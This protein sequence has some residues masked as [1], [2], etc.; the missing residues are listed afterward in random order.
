MTKIFI[1]IFLSSLIPA[2]PCAA[3]KNPECMCDAYELMLQNRE[4][5][6]EA[7]EMLGRALTDTCDEEL[8]EFYKRS[9]AELEK[10]LPEFIQ[11][12]GGD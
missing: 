11:Y 5:Y 1:A 7:I 8:I 3:C 2:E 4:K 9:C 10:P 6:A 12:T